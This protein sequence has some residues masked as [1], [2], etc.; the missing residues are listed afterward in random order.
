MLC[1]LLVYL[2]S[3]A[4]HT[5]HVTGQLQLG[6]PWPM[7]GRN[8]LHTSNSPFLT[9][10]LT[11]G[12]LRWKL[13]MGSQIQSSPSIGAD[14]T[15]FFGTD[16]GL[17]YAVRSTGEV[18]WKYQTRGAVIST[19]AL[20]QKDM[21]F[22]GS[23]DKQL[24]A[25]R[26]STGAY[27]WLYKVTDIIQSSP[28]IDENNNIYFCSGSN[29]YALYDTGKL[30]WQVSVRGISAVSPALSLDGILFLT[31]D[32][33]TLPFNSLISLRASDGSK[34]VDPSFFNVDQVSYSSPL[35]S[36]NSKECSLPSFANGKECS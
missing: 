29:V 30:K 8:Q 9:N 14:G 2:S 15:I 18:I 35:V 7:Y 10:P 21:I 13:F 20:S 25:L 1:T 23:W 3:I 33:S 26:A 16:A 19:P 6:S 4:Y 36:L 12:K 24:Y 32:V 27:L 34:Y 17:V 22:F 11:D 31:N 5:Y 28:V